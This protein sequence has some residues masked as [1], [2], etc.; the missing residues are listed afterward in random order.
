LQGVWTPGH[1]RQE[2]LRKEGAQGKAGG[3]IDR[4]LGRAKS[5]KKNGKWTAEESRKQ[6]GCGALGCILL[7]L[8]RSLPPVARVAPSGLKLQQ[9]TGPSCPWSSVPQGKSSALWGCVSNCLSHSRT[10]QSSELEIEKEKG[11]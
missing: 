5:R 2:V 10:V 11:F 1:F 4:G 7:Q 6:R 3:Q 8:T 9:L